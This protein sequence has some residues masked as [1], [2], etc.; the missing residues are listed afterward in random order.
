ME[1][2]PVE[3]S[4]LSANALLRLVIEKYSLSP[5]AGITFLKRG[6]NDTYLIKTDKNKYILRVYKHNW[7]SPQSI[8]SEIDLLNY[9]S[10]NDVP[11]SVPVIDRSGNYMQALQAPEGPRN[12]VLF[13]YASGNPVKKL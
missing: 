7:R 11:V 6:F 5:T 4:S 8:K 12:A 1:Q 9:L 3:Y 10:K 13:T 2:F